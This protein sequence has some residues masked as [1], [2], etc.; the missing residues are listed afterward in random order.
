MLSERALDHGQKIVSPVKHRLHILAV[1][2]RI[3]VNAAAEA[4][5]Q[6]L[7]ELLGR[8]IKIQQ[9]RL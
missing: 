3:G 8:D 4:L 9:D 2:H 6:R 7:W 5:P 1:P